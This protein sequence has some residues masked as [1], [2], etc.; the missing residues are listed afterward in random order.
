MLV[1][2]LIPKFVPSVLRTSDPDHRQRCVRRASGSMIGVATGLLHGGPRYGYFRTNGNANTTTTTAGGRVGRSVA[3][4]AREG[5]RARRIHSHD[6]LPGMLHGKIFRARS[7]MAISRLTSAAENPG[8]YRVVT[9]TTLPN[10]PRPYYGR[11]STTADLAITR[12]ASSATGGGR[13]HPIPTSPRRR[14]RKSLRNTRNCPR[15]M[16]RSRR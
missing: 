12:S 8:V 14:R 2:R 7:R 10:H 5:Q 6:D 4:E 15:S 1:L 3:V 16:T 9:P 13:G 11:P